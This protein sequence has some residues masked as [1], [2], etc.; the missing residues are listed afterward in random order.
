[1]KSKEVTIDGITYTVKATTDAGLKRGISQLKR[2]LK[3]SKENDER[4][5]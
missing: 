1:M 3:K 4:G 5:E 2:S